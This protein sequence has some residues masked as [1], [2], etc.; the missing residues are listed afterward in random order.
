MKIR[1][2]EPALQ[3]L[4]ILESETLIYCKIE[5]IKLR[6]QDPNSKIQLLHM[7]IWDYSVQIQNPNGKSTI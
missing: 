7:K 1:Y 2:P 4:Y 5:K 6:V 3:Q